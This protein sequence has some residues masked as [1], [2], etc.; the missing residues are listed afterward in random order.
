MSTH[1][2]D[3]VRINEI[4]K[5]PNA[6][7]LG[8]VLIHGFTCAVRLGDFQV[9]DLCAYIEPD[10]IVPSP[11]EHVAGAQFAFLGAHRRI[12]AKRLRGTWSQGLLVRAPAGAAEGDD[13]MEQLGIKRWEPP[14]EFGADGDAER[15]CEALAYVPKYDL[16]N[17]RRYGHL[18]HDQEIVF[19][20]EKLHG[21]N[22]RFA[23]REGRMWAGSRTQWKR[24]P[25]DG[26]SP[27]DIWWQAIRQ[28]PWIAPWCEA[29]QDAVLYA[30]VFGQVQNLRYDTGKGEIRCRA[31]DILRGNS[32]VGA[33]EFWGPILGDHAR[34]PLLYTGPYSAAKMEELALADS[35]LAKHL[36]EG[37]VITPAE[38]RS[39]PEI[40]RVK[41]KLVSNRY[42]EKS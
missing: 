9:G 7:S 28:N 33:T 11:E 31:F 22:A 15:P 5:H 18:F 25:E 3:V 30:E 19:V 41:L 36:S 29:H 4:V 13:V 16:E 10:Y 32:W 21:A 42:L 38:E 1:R 6:D 2:V 35:T 12:K 37:A 8:L 27:G 20:T 23:F 17:W 14:I 34:V 39:D 40:G 24:P 26:G